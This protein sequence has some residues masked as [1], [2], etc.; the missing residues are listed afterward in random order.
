MEGKILNIYVKIYNFSVKLGWEGRL[1]QTLSR[2][3]FV[4]WIFYNIPA[5]VVEDGRNRPQ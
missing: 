1:R 4:E 5:W 2:V 3:G